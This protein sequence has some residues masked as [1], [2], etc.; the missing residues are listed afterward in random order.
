MRNHSTF[1]NPYL[2]RHTL[3]AIAGVVMLAELATSAHA[4]ELPTFLVRRNDC[5]TV[6]GLSWHTDYAAACDEARSAK[7]MLLVNFVPRDES[8]IQNGFEKS[9]QQVDAIRA[10]LDDFVLVRVGENRRAG[11][12]LFPLRKKNR[13]RLI[14]DAAFKHLGQSPGLAIIDFEH[15]DESYYGQVVTVLPFKNGKYYRWKNSQ[16]EVALGLPA[17]TITQRMMVWAVRIHPEQPQSTVGTM[18]PELAALATKHSEYQAQ[19]GVQGH[20][21]FENRAQTVRFVTHSNEVSEVVAESWEN[22]DL[23]DSCIDCVASWR[24]S[25]GHWAGVSSRHRLYGYDIRKGSN[26]IWY[27]TGLFAN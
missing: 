12:L 16:F 27:G 2:G 20:Q 15:A 23:I 10:K 8:D 19:I 6:A 25:P 7:K 26:G 17:G 3:A 14:D 24:Q 22:Q 1:Q 4:I 11:N 9:L 21:H 5:V 18:H 13:G